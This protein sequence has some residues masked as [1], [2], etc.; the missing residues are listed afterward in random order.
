MS[1]G[2]PA[3]S[4]R[5]ADP[6]EILSAFDALEVHDLV[7]LKEFAK[8]RIF[9]IGPR[10]AHG[11]TADDLFNE[12]V[13]RMLD[14]TRKW[15][16]ERVDLMKYL[17]DA[18][19]SV[20]SGWAGHRKRNRS[21]PEYAVVEADLIKLDE[22]GD[23]RSPV[24]D[25]ASSF[26]TPEDEMLYSEAETEP[27]LVDE[28]EASFA[29]DEQA[30]LVLVGLQEGLGGPQIRQECGL[31]E[32]EYRTVVRRIKRRALKLAEGRHGT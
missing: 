2:Q 9:R 14:G 7:R 1:K 16:P 13:K 8:T 29:D 31:T 20:S 24:D 18:I 28:I 19:R 3:E 11:R 17:F 21:S 32:K 6:E 27:D 15:Q 12:T 5:V 25:V 30:T 10:A 4:H 23:P 22:D 26:N